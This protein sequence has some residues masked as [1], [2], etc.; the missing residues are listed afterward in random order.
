MFRAA[1]VP[2]AA[3]AEQPEAAAIIGGYREAGQRRL[4]R[5]IA[6]LEAPLP[7]SD[8]R[9]TPLVN[10]LAAGLRRWTDA[11]IGIV[12][13]GQ[14]LGG[15]ALGD[16]TAGELH[17][18]CP[19]PINPCRLV[20][21]GRHI[22]EALEQSL[23]PEYIYKPI[24][25]YGFRGKVLG[26]LAIDGMTVSYDSTRPAMNRIVAAEVNG[27]P[28]ADEQLYTVGSIDMFTFKIGYESL[29]LAEERRYYMP[30]F[31]RDIIAS[32]LTSEVE[33]SDC[34]RLRWSN[35]AASL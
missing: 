14:L 31:I 34:H 8:E 19:S 4:S 13:A 27:L 21:A 12:N 11:E 24:K 10:L 33:L 35:Q 20:I 5:V 32:Q 17:A 6:R 22:R 9:E 23:L 29:A 26:S 16:V 28:L 25:G 15:L 1:C 18:L 7:A 30:E 2:T 3:L